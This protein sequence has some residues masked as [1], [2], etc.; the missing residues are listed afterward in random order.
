MSTSIIYLATGVDD[1]HVHVPCFFTSFY[2]YDPY[3]SLQFL[4]ACLHIILIT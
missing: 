2:F 1:L 3:L 4:L